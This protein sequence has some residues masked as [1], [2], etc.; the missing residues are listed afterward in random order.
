MTDRI[1]G[2]LY[3]KTLASAKE[4][5]DQLL[6]E[7]KI[8][9]DE[10]LFRPIFRSIINAYFACYRHNRCLFF[11]DSKKGYIYTTKTDLPE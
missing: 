10:V 7:E 6:I 3:Y 11:Y 8:K 2:K 1:T 5:T 4:A 9:S